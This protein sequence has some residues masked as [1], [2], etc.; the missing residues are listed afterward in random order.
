MVSSEFK[1]K[2]RPAWGDARRENS[3]LSNLKYF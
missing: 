3:A 1:Y 2:D